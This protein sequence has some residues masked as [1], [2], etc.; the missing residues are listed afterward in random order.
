MLQPSAAAR[1]A[2]TPTH[3]TPHAFP[4]RASCAQELGL[5]AAACTAYVMR[6]PRLIGMEAADLR[7]GLNTL[8]AAAGVSPGEARRMAL[9]AP[10]LL[11]VRGWLGVKACIHVAVRG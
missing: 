7:M 2:R 4:S 1:T 9:K 3:G 6:H 5:S 8:E 11:L 10:Q